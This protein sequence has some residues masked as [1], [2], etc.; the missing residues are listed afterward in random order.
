MSWESVLNSDLIKQDRKFVSFL[1]IGSL[2]SVYWYP[3]QG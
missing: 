3:R 2:K 1:H